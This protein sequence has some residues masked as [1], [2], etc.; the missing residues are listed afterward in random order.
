MKLLGISIVITVALYMLELNLIR[1]S[2]RIRIKKSIFILLKILSHLVYI[3]ALCGVAW[4][5]I[6][7]MC[8][9]L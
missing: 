2:K 5:I 4:C 8:Y 1:W 3:F 9:F 6:L 7:A